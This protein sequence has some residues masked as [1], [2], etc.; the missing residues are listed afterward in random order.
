MIS[1][2][3]F[4]NRKQSTETIEALEESEVH[5]ITF[6]QLQKI[7]ELFPE[8]R[9]I[10]QRLTEIYYCASEVRADDLRMKQADELYSDWIR[11]QSELAGRIKKS[12]LASYFG[13][14][15][16]TLSRA[17]KAAKMTVAYEP[18]WAIGTG[19]T[20]TPQIAASAHAVIRGEAEEAFG[21]EFAEQL[22]ILYGGSMKPDNAKALMSEAEID[23]GLV[24]GASLDAKSFAAIVKY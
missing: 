15:P 20:A 5:W 18:V 10:G 11:N 13:I 24:G 9:R 22:R 19:K 21:A 3:S 16:P 6:D 17:K 23:G 7:Y 8:F 4:F 1:V 2:N 14:T 12:Y